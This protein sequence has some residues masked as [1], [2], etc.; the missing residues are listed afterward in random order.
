MKMEQTVPKRRHVKFKRG[1]I[2]QKK[3]NI[4]VSNQEILYDSSSN[5]HVTTLFS[6][7]R[8]RSACGVYEPAETHLFPFPYLT[9]ETQNAI[10]FDAY[11]K[12]CLTGSKFRRLGTRRVSVL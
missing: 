8:V 3:E 7:V 6:V 1:G 12:Q 10:I 2:P 5:N 9:L 11:H 4:R